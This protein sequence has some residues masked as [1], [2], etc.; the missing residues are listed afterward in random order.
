MSFRARV[1]TLCASRK[2]SGRGSIALGLLA[3]LAASYLMGISPAQ[4]ND[5][6]RDPAQSALAT[7]VPIPTQGQATATPAPIPL[8]V[9]PNGATATPVIPTATRAVL[10][11]PGSTAAPATATPV[12]PLTLIHI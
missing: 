1:T 5:E 10:S 4:A 3:M 2:L 12:P 11:T 8:P 6:G 7:P 9:T